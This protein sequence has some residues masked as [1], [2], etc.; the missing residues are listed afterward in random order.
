MEIKV[1]LNEYADVP[2][3]KKLLSQLKG[4]VDVEV[5]NEKLEKDYDEKLDELL[6]LSKNQI[7]EGKFTEHSDELLNSF[8]K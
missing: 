8:F 1:S 6:S 2:F 3:I 5:E 4:V 7:K